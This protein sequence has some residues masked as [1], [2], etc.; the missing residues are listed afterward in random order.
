MCLELKLYKF[1][2]YYQV[3]ATEDD[4]S[5]CPKMENN[6]TTISREELDE[7]REAFGKIGM[8]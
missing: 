1:L 4:T 6:I 8:F 7:L 5:C 3:P 2:F